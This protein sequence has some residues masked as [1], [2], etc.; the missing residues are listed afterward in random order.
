[1]LPWRG[2]WA[3]VEGNKQ[4]F[5]VAPRFLSMMSV[6]RLVLRSGSG[7]HMIGT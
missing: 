6:A 4:L 5:T 3:V 1:M 2:T 7:V